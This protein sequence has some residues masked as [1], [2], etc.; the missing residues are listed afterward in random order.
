MA[1]MLT[2]S[3]SSPLA[4]AGSN[5]HCLVNSNTRV[6]CPEL[7]VRKLVDSGMVDTSMLFSVAACDN[8]THYR[9]PSS[10]K[11]IPRCKVCDGSYDCVIYSPSYIYDYADENYCPTGKIL[12]VATD[13]AS[14]RQDSLR[15]DSL[16]HRLAY[17]APGFMLL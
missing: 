8:S 11:C 15:Q 17:R 12:M 4:I 9:C 7:L 14:L 6:A 5:L 3:H 13:V 1:L 16:K 2:V 10:R